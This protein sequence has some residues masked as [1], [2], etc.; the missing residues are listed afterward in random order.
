MD[1]RTMLSRGAPRRTTRA[2]RAVLAVLSTA[3]LTILLGTVPASGQVPGQPPAGPTPVPAQN[4]REYR[5]PPSAVNPEGVV[6]DARSQSFYTSSSNVSGS[7]TKVTYPQGVATPFTPPIT[8]GTESNGLAIDTRNR[9]YVA[10]GNLARLDV[11]NLA[12][13]QRVARFTVPPGSFVNDVTINP[14]TGDAY[15]TDS[16]NARIFRVTAAQVAAGTGTP[17]IIPTA[18]ETTSAPIGTNSTKPFNNNGIRFT[19]DGRFIVFDDLN[20]SALYVMT[21][22]PPSAPTQ[23]QIFRVPITNGNLGDADGLEFNGPFLYV[24]D[25][26]G[27][28]VL[29]LGVDPSFRGARILSATTSPLYHTPTAAALAPNNQLLVPQSQLFEPVG[30]PYTV[31]SQTRP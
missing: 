7:I 12:N 20:D 14:R 15:F 28:R 2:A 10:R 5:L 13:A 19:P 22:P 29:K 27:E 30:P 18:P 24:V 16:F 25:N 9:L 8:E 26:G 1:R 6:Y 4:I 3:L 11:Y 31:T 17:Q 21:I 23:R